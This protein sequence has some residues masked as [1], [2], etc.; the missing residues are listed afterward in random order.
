MKSAT[1]L[2]VVAAVVGIACSLNGEYRTDAAAVRS[3]G[4]KEA[5]D[6]R[7]GSDENGKYISSS[8]AE[9]RRRIEAK[10]AM[11][12]VLGERLK[13]ANAE[14]EVCRREL[15]EKK[16]RDAAMGLE[17]LTDDV[18][19][20]QQKLV[21]AVRDLYQ[22]EQSRKEAREMLAKLA[23][24]VEPLLLK[25]PEK[26]DAKARADLVQVVAG[27]RKTLQHESSGGLPEAADWRSAKVVEV[28]KDRPFVVLNTGWAHG[29]KS[30]M[31]FEIVRAGRVLALCKAV[32]V[33]ERLCGALLE[34]EGKTALPRIGDGARVRVERSG[35]Q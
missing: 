9:L 14:A 33:R 6:R 31:V 7:A 27:A 23:D 1:V 28:M 29:V 22:A 11:M 26:W 34:E 16:L 8:E 20:M 19:Q 12:R 5:T 30:G 10:E 3:G 35:K 18:K 21:Y 17:L 32:D 2:F 13:S 25:Q 4:L 24:S 15:D